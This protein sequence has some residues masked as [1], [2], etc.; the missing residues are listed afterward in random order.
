MHPATPRRR[1]ARPVADAPTEAL[2]ERTDEL[3]KGWLLELIDQAPLAAAPAIL[4]GEVVSS[5]PSLCEAIVRAL[6]SD[7]AL[8]ALSAGGRQAA[9]VSRVGDVA[10]AS[11]PEAVMRALDALM[12]VVWS[13]I[14]GALAD[15]EGDL[16]AELAERLA[17]VIE[18]VRGVALAGTVGSAAP[19]PPKRPEPPEPSEPSEPPEFEPRGGTE[20]RVI[21]RRG[22]AL[23]VGAIE[24]A[25]QSALRTSAPMSLLLV[26]LDDADRVVAVE[27]PAAA[28]ST[29][30]RFAQA[31]RSVVR[32]EDTLACES[33]SRAWI[34]APSDR[35][36]AEALARRVSDAV[37]AAH[38][39]RGAPMTVGVGLAVLGEDGV[40]SARLMARAEQERF[41]AAAG[42]LEFGSWATPDDDPPGPGPRLVE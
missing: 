17:R 24:D 40:D 14:R 13:A 31:V 22:Q 30:G 33:G 19:A 7:R 35:A 1:R 6:A 21:D 5:G 15:P 8:E 16:V 20:S 9:L 12:A 2:L 32:R 27:D 26:E 3:A 28:T 25:V 41:A 10:G 37:R 36:A 23:W 39:W 42:G 18:V 11:G 29:F 38:P 4:A 34:I